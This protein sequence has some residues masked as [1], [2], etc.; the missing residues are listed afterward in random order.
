MAS[1]LVL[2][3]RPDCHLCDQARDGLRN[4]IAEGLPFE[5]EEVNIESDEGL[6]ARFLER[7]PVIELDGEIVSELGLDERALRARLGTLSE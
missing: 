2:Y 3:G 6:H 5:L 1:R 4:L 7:I